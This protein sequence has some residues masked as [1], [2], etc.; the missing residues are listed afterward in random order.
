MVEPPASAPVAPPV[1]LEV[2]PP[3]ASSAPAVRAAASATTR[4]GGEGALEA[5]R[6]VLDVARTA[7]GRGDGSNALR[8]IDEHARK[9]PRGALAEEREAMAIQALRL[10]HRDDEAQARLGRFRGRFPTSLIRPALEADEG[11]A[12]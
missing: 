2:A 9:F 11:G 4:A 1:D 3:K 5:E 7:L 8:A 6:A 12:P 10:L